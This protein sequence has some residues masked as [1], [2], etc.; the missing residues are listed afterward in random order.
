[1]HWIVGAGGL[2][3]SSVVSTAPTTI[4]I[5]RPNR[6]V[7]WSNQAQWPEHFAGALREMRDVD[8]G[9]G[10]S[11]WW[12][13]GRGTVSSSLEELHDERRALEVLLDSLARS[14]KRWRERGSIVFSSSAGAVYAGTDEVPIRVDSL[15][16]PFTA[17][18][19]I[20][21]ELEELVRR[22]ASEIG[23][24]SVIARIT[25]L[26]GPRQDLGKGQGLVSRVCSAILSREPVPVFVSLG[27]V[28]NYVYASD[29]AS[30]S[31][32]L[33]HD[34]SRGE[35]VTSIICSPANVSVGGVLKM[36]ELIADRQ[37]LTRLEARTDS[38]SLSRSVFFD[39]T[40]S[41]SASFQYTPFHVGVHRV[42]SALLDEWR[43]GRVAIAGSTR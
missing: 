7:E 6:R 41:G 27:T 38:E 24:R 42:H 1:V 11:I 8:D 19:R 34:E 17:Y 18:G 9:D 23:M 21:L 12:C 32:R 20:K 13:A 29:A 33:F 3:G 35:T 2:L 4:R 31:W 30:L 28:R 25:N 43:K 14:P 26:Y 15:P 16:R 40:V 39:P 37:P 10:W 22:R 36:C 5:W